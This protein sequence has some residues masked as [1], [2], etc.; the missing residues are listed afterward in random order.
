MRLTPVDSSMDH[1]VGETIDFYMGRNTPERREY[2]MD[3]LVITE[4]ALL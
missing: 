2:I 4:D 1:G 3:H